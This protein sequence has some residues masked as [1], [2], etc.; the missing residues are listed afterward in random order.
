MKLKSLLFILLLFSNTVFGQWYASLTNPNVSIDLTHPPKLMLKVDRVAFYP[1]YRTASREMCDYLLTYFVNDGR[2]QIIDRQHLDHILMEQNLSISGRIDPQTALKLGKLLGSAAF[3]F[4]KVYRDGYEKKH[5]IETYK[6]NGKEK[7]KYI[8]KVNVFFK[9]SVQTTDLTTGRIFQAN[10]IEKD[11]SAENTNYENGYP[12]YPSVEKIRGDL[13]KEV[14]Y[15][16]STY[17]LSWKEHLSPVFFNDKKCGMRE[18]YE[19]LDMGDLESATRLS[20]R[21]VECVKSSGRIKAKHKS[22][23]FYNLGMCYFLARDY[24][25][26]AELFRKAYAIKDYG[27]YKKA[28]KNALRA[29]KL[30]QDLL[31]VEAMAPLNSNNTQAE[32]KQ[33]KKEKPVRKSEESSGGS[34]IE[35]KLEK[36]KRLF[37]KGLITKEE[38]DKKREELINQL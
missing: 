11:R 18:A 27:M 34:D 21:A 2:I 14:A 29:K 23:A 24:D 20:Q 19:A 22:R 15:E 4:V 16:I 10:M 35:K 13:M 30:E 26:A 17:F 25:K 7:Q 8:S 38:Y 36:L 12:E 3:V 5:L 28:V 33:V 9:V 31:K 6:S 37:D 32:Q 1:D